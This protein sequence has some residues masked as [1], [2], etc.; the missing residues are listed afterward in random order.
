MAAAASEKAKAM[1]TAKVATDVTAD[2]GNA[3]TALETITACVTVTAAATMTATDT[4]TAAAPLVETDMAATL[5]AMDVAEAQLTAAT[6]PATVSVIASK[7][8]PR[9]SQAELS[10]DG[11]FTHI[12]MHFRIR[13]VGLLE[14]GPDAFRA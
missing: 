14:K 7:F 11:C 6:I 2:A 9:T 8:R 4:A 13:A 1:S 3:V 10:A 5:T 12:R